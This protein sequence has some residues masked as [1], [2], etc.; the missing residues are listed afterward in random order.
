MLHNLAGDSEGRC[1]YDALADVGIGRKSSMKEVRDSSFVLMEEYRWT[2][3][4]R[5]AWNELRMVERRL[6]VDFLHYDRDTQ[7]PRT[8]EIL[9][10]AL[11]RQPGSDDVEYD[12]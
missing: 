5:T 1:P 9:L 2:P 11:L 10:E 8:G 6:L 12:R 7:L 4:V 3:E